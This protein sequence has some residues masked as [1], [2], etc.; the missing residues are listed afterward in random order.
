MLKQKFLTCLFF[1]FFLIA[2]TGFG[3]TAAFSPDQKALL[4]EALRVALVTEKNLPDYEFLP[5]KEKIDIL[6]K[7]VSIED[8]DKAPVYLTPEVLPAFEQVKFNLR[9]EAY[10]KKNK[11]KKNHLFIRLGQINQPEGDYALVHL[12]GQWQLGKKNR[13]RG[14]VSREAWGQTM[15]F[16]KTDGTW[17]F[18]KVVN[19]FPNL[20]EQENK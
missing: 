15:L 3:Q 18:E 2:K 7:M 4:A 19:K 16:K 12:Y 14:L 20:F 9:N 1:T 8:R 10:F 11:P 5:N 13:K 17:K 6:D